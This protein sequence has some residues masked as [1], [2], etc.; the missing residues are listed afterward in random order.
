M[1]VK[2]ATG[3]NNVYSNCTE[4]ITRLLQE[5]YRSHF[6]EEC[7]LFG[8]NRLNFWDWQWEYHSSPPGHHQWRCLA[9]RHSHMGWNHINSLCWWCSCHGHSHDECYPSSCV[10]NTQIS[11]ELSLYNFN[12]LSLGRCC[13][14]FK[15]VNCKH[16]LRIDHIL[17]FQVNI[18]LEWMSENL[19][20]DHSVTCHPDFSCTN[21]DQ[22]L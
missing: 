10:S 1:L 12:S 18:T 13:C 21:A 3:C 16:N 14:D 8:S 5:S 15:C 9:Q 6:C 4:M 17:S 19:G 7:G 2:G 22:G 20:D 11:N